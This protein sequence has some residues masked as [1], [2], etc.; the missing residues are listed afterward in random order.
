[1][2]HKL[3]N[4]LILLA[5]AVILI[6][7]V[8]IYRIHSAFPY[9]EDDVNG[10]LSGNLYNGGYF[11]ESNGTIFFS[12][13]DDGYSL[14]SMTVNGKNLTKLSSD[15]ACF[16]NADDHYV[17]YTQ[18]TAEGSAQSSLF[19][20]N[21][22]SLCRI[23]REGGD[24]VLLDTDPCIYAALSGNYIYYLHYSKDAGTTLYKI[25]IDGSGKEEVLKAPY[26]MCDANG[27]YFYYHGVENDHNLYRFDTSTDT[28]APIF[29]G[30][31]YQPILSGDG[32]Y[33]IDCDNNYS[34]AKVDLSTGEKTTIIPDRIDRYT[35]NDNA[36]YY[37]KNDAEYP[38]LRKA[39]LDGTSIETLASG[40]YTDLNLTSNYLYFKR[41]KDDSV[42]YRI[43]LNGDGKMEAFHPGVAKD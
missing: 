7:I 20:W 9:N 16:I 8:I 15:Y 37:Q 41:F 25:N 30:N 1:M 17:Y 21:T 23:S 31:T 12:N 33:F 29:V 40:N 14:Y 13:P 26:M 5:I 3:R 11:C 24:T 39:S 27:R 36:I 22:N 43:A 34:L 10:N 18:N 4:F 6:L 28:S 38:E 32:I 19:R 2:K 42:V 35:V